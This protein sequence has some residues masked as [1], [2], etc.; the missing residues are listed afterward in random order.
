MKE[1]VSL[2]AIALALFAYVPYYRDIFKGTTKPHVYSW[3]L[4][5]LSGSLLVALQFVGGAG[6]AAWVTA[7][8]TLLCFGVFLLSLKGGKRH[9]TKLDTAMATLSLAAIVFWL[10]ADQPIVSMLLLIASDILAFI[11]TVRKSWINPYSE[12]LLTYVVHTIRYT[13]TLLAVQDYTI[14]STLSI[15]IWTGVNGLFALMLVARRK[16]VKPP[17]ARRASVA[18][19]QLK[20]A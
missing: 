18:R 17:R 16:Q 13:L 4:W 6:P 20:R 3:G 7:T 9:I 14:L 12:T 2:V 5:S 10:I 11:P 8:G 1:I 19:R 15:A